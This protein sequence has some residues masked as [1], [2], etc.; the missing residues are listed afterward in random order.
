MLSYDKIN[1]KS[2]KMPFLKLDIS[3]TTEKNK[4]LKPK[5]SAIFVHCK[6]VLENPSINN[7]KVTD[8]HFCPF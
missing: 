3:K 8:C 2:A 1:G 6:L 5:I 7:L 4:Q